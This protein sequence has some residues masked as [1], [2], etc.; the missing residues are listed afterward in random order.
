MRD[1]LHHFF[2]PVGGLLERDLCARQGDVGAAE[3]DATLGRELL[4]LEIPR[5]E[6]AKLLG[7][8]F[9]LDGEVSVCVFGSHSCGLR[10]RLQLQGACE[11]ITTLWSRCKASGDVGTS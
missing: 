8:R 1:V 7:E 2:A 3:L 5:V 10:P 9:E 11:Q 6:L 4:E